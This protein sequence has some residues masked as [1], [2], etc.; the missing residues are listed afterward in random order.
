MTR[1][2]THQR[3][4]VEFDPTIKQHR[5]WYNDFLQ[6]SSWSNCPVRFTI[7]TDGDEGNTQAII[8]RKLAQHYLDKEFKVKAIARTKMS[9]AA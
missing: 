5:Q 2:T 3:P 1:L 4:L 6:T 8:Q 7:Q 9:V